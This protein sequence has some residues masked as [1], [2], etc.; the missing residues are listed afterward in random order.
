MKSSLFLDIKTLLI[1]CL[2]RYECPPGLAYSAESHSCLWIS[3]VPECSF[4]T[5]PIDETEEFACPLDTPSGAFTKHA[6]P[7]DCRQFFLCIGGIPREQGCPLG[8]VFDEGESWERHEKCCKSC[9]ISCSMMMDSLTPG[10]QRHNDALRYFLTFKTKQ[11]SKLRKINQNVTV[12]MVSLVYS[13]ME[14]FVQTVSKQSLGSL[15]AV[16]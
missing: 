13:K 10:L 7:L 12:R 8:E 3:E 1:L 11:I 9:K 16:S 15:L 4:K 14:V 2:I 6:H 5:V